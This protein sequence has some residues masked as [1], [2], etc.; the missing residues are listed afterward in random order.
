MYNGAPSPQSTLGYFQLW[1][2][3]AAPPVATPL[4]ILRALIHFRGLEL[5]S[6]PLITMSLIPT[7]PWTRSW[8]RGS[9]M[10][11]AIH[12]TFSVCS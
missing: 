4:A 9:N 3:G 1:G 6:P 8:V 2:G 5:P 11:Q 7:P 10:L 12:I